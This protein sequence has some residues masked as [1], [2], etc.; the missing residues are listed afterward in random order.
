VSTDLYDAILAS[1][2]ESEAAR[3]LFVVPDGKLHLLAFDALLDRHGPES[4]TVSVA[5]SAN[6]FALLQTMRPATRPP[7][8]L[9]GVGGVPY[10][11]MFPSGKPAVAARSDGMRGL[12]DASYPTQ[13]P[14]LPTAEGEVVAA[15]RVLGPT[16]AVLTGDRATES[17]VKAQKLGDFDVLHFAVHAFA[18]PKFPERAALVLLNDAAGEDDGLLQPR[19]IGQFRLSAGVV[20]LSACDTAVGPTLGQEGVLNIARAFLLA[21]ARSVITT[22]WAVSDA[23]ST[24]LMRRFY[25]NLAGGESVATALARSKATV[26]EQFGDDARSTVAAFQLIGV[27]EHRVAT[28]PRKTVGASVGR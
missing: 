25:E 27:G 13:L 18:D 2:P 3:R 6:V 5:P 4:R 26:L 21:G 10:D 1:I 17:A 11:R 15:A 24:A 16:S 12:L 14:V 28:A 8:A 23:T 20:V 9:M 22:L 7:R 19:E